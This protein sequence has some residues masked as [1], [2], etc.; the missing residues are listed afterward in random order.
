M[1]L[2]FSVE[3]G[4]TFKFCEAQLEYSRDGV[5]KACDAYGC[6][7]LMVN[8]KLGVLPAPPIARPFRLGSTVYIDF[9][10]K[11]YVEPGNIIWASAPI[12]LEVYKSG[13]PVARLSPTRAKYTLVGSLVDGVIARYFKVLPSLGGPPSTSTA[14][15]SALIAFFI[16]S[17]KDVVRG[18]PFNASQVTFYSDMSNLYYSLVEVNIKDVII[19]SR[20]TSKPPRDKLIKVRTV[21]EGKGLGFGTTTPIVSVERG[22]KLWP[23]LK[24]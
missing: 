1:R 7:E 24:E 16:S 6:E 14:P 8:G 5:L 18:V 19:E 23:G 11:V 3:P 13:R 20:T 12:E 9:T 4:T 22:W 15:C 10:R 21:R 2:P 17:G